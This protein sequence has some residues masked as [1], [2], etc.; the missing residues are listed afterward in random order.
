[1]LL[2][3]MELKLLEL[4][5]DIVQLENEKREYSDGQQKIN[6]IMETSS[7][8]DNCSNNLIGDINSAFQCGDVT[9]MIGPSLSDVGSQYNKRIDSMTSTTEQQGKVCDYKI[10]QKQLEIEQLKRQIEI[11]KNMRLGF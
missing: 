3:E 5:N 4:E 9:S 1:M 7:K 8:I 10:K 11:E 2:Q 6:Q